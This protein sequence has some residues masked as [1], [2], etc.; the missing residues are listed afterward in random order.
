M[1]LCMTL[2]NVHFFILDTESKSVEKLMDTL[3][4]RPLS[5]LPMSGPHFHITDYSEIPTKQI[6]INPRLTQSD[7]II[8]PEFYP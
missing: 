8:H 3:T 6:N 1:L 5:G 4:S 2:Q 7:F